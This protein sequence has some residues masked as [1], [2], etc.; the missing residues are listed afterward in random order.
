L[1][2]LNLFGEVAE[3]SKAETR[4]GYYTVKTC[5]GGSNPSPLRQSYRL[6]ATP[7]ELGTRLVYG[8]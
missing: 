5:I 4:K 8:G 6:K 2:V 7:I 1:A 3:R